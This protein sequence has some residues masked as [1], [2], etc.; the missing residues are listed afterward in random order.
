MVVIFHYT[1]GSKRVLKWK[2]IKGK[3]DRPD[4][5]SQSDYL[6]DLM[7]DFRAESYEIK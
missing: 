7:H 5:Y 6:R 4:S 3:A 1:D 2:P